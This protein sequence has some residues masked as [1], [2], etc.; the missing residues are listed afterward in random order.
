MKEEVTIIPKEKCIGRRLLN[1]EKSP[2]E[3]S[4]QIQMRNIV[5]MKYIRLYG[6]AFHQKSFTFNH[7]T[8]CFEGVWEINLDDYDKDFF[9]GSNIYTQ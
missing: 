4:A 2:P 7:N 1:G 5:E 6:R 3:L 9:T 8:Q